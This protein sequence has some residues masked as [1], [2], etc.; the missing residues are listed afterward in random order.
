M[1]K[2]DDIIYCYRLTNSGRA[3]I[4]PPQSHRGVSNVIRRCSFC[5]VNTS[6]EGESE[7]LSNQQP[8]ECCS[9]V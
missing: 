7:R 8:S 5:Y 2:G 6:L 3:F 4:L 1:P 9:L